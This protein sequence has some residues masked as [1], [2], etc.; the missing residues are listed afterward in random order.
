MAQQVFKNPAAQAESL[1]KKEPLT[2]EQVIQA[3]K[4][5]FMPNYYDKGMYDYTKMSDDDVYNAYLDEVENYGD[6]VD[7]QL[8][9]HLKGQMP[10]GRQIDVG[11][12]EYDDVDADYERSYGPVN[13]PGK[14][15]KY[16]EWKLNGNSFKSPLDE[17]NFDILHPTKAQSEALAKLPRFNLNPSNPYKK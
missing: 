6:E 10:K 11:E 8:G 1:A 14:Y 17:P 13:T 15:K 3:M 5:W 16:Q 9:L 7:E 12:W 2:R 4:E